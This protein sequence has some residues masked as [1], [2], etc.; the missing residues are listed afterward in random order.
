MAATNTNPVDVTLFVRRTD[1]ADT[2]TQAVLRLLGDGA[3]HSAKAIVAAIP[4]LTTRDI[5]D[6]RT[7]A[8]G[9]I[10]GSDKGYKLTRCA[11][12][13]ETDRYI[14][15]CYKN[16]RDYQQNAVHVENFRSRR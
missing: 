7:R 9:A 3:W 5:R 12:K 6:I 10:I 2:Y 11:T 4:E 8:R 16:M 1:K 14:R 13:A 15:M